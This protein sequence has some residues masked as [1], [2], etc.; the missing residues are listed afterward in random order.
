MWKLNK[1]EVFDISCLFLFLVWH[2]EIQKSNSKTKTVLCTV[3]YI[4]NMDLF[5][6]LYIKSFGTGCKLFRYLWIKRL[7]IMIPTPEIF[8][9]LR[10][11]KHITQQSARYSEIWS[12]ASVGGASMLSYVKGD[13]VTRVFNPRVFSSNYSPSGPN[14]RTKPFRI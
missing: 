13:S 11:K 6:Y 7:G 1:K 3:H 2:H 9:A 5:C 4:W 8:S 12:N 14:S 10:D